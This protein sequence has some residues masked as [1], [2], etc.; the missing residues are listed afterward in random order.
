M[1]QSEK[2]GPHHTFEGRYE[3]HMVK[4]T[5]GHFQKRAHEEIFIIFYN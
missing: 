5:R 2:L 3:S 1:Q 4:K